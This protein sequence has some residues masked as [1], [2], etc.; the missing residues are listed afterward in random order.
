MNKAA[1]NERRKIT[2]TAVNTLAVSM[3]VTG[4]V[5]P[6]V[7]LSYQLGEPKTRFWALFMLTWLA[8]GFGLH[9]VSRQ[10]LE[11]LEE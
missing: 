11:G 10:I 6:I 9:L 8:F 1:R 7:T 5:V 3:V 2:A 4:A